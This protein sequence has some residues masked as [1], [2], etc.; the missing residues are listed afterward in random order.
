MGYV[1]HQ[2]GGLTD[3]MFE[4]D[5]RQS[6]RERNWFKVNWN[7]FA[8]HLN[9][10]FNATSEFNV[11]LFGLS[12]Y[13]YSVGFRPNRVATI[14]DNSERDLIKG[15]FTNWGAEAD[16]QTLFLGKMPLSS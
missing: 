4:Q 6:N 10:K 15:D 9:H 5:P 1:A 14:D 7:L 12:A 3:E 2:P 13:R 16:I 11:R 8:L